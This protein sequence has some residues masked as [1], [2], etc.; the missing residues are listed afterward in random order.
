M[1]LGNFLNCPLVC[2]HM[3]GGE[4]VAIGA[5]K[6]WNI[7]YWMTSLR[8]RQYSFSKILKFFNK[9]YSNVICKTLGPVKLKPSGQEGTKVEV[10][11]RIYWM[12]RLLS[13]HLSCQS[14]WPG[15][16]QLADFIDSA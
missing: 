5:H 7:F 14:G 13:D 12:G 10:G 3:Q 16:A 1:D 4:G 8:L 6:W 2:M 9:R 11:G 15:M